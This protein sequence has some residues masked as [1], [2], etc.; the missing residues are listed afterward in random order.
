[1]DILNPWPCFFGNIWRLLTS[2]LFTSFWPLLL[3][4]GRSF[5]VGVCLQREVFNLRKLFTPPKTQRHAAL[6]WVGQMLFGGEAD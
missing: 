2:P 3:I 1:M 4:Y 5:W 6:L